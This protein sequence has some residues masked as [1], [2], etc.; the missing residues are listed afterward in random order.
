MSC[1]CVVN[2]RD[3]VNNLLGGSVWCL[4]PRIVCM[5]SSSQTAVLLVFTCCLTVNEIVGTPI[6]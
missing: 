5:P 4:L 6:A 2:K 3:D 1:V